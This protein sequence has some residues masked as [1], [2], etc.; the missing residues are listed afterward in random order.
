MW[1]MLYFLSPLTASTE[2]HTSAGPEWVGCM[3]VNTFSK[4]SYEMIIMLMFTNVKHTFTTFIY[5]TNNQSFS[6]YALLWYLLCRLLF[7]SFICFIPLCSHSLLLSYFPGVVAL[8][9]LGTLQW[10]SQRK[11]LWISLKCKNT[12]CV[13]GGGTNCSFKK[14]ELWIQI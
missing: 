6:H 8:C 7:T 3:A 4:F 2:A 12:V 11:T 1:L 13:L 5:W 14:T 9:G 10:R